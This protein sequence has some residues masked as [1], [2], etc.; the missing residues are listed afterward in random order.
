MKY[1]IFISFSLFL[2]TFCFSVNNASANIVCL[3]PNSDYVVD[4]Q[5]ECDHEFKTIAELNEATKQG[6]VIGPLVAGDQVWFK[7][8]GV[9]REPLIVGSSGEIDKPIIY[10]AYG[11]TGLRRPEISCS[12]D[13]TKHLTKGVL[14]NGNFEDTPAGSSCDT[15]EW[16]DR[17]WY[18]MSNCAAIYNE[19]TDNHVLQVDNTAETQQVKS[20]ELGLQSGTQ[21]QIKGEIRTSGTAS[22]ELRLESLTT[23]EYFGDD[24]IWHA[25]S[26]GYLPFKTIQSITGVSFNELLPGIDS[27]RVQLRMI[28]SGTGSVWFDNIEIVDTQTN[29]WSAKTYKNG[30]HNIRILAEGRNL[31][32]LGGDGVRLSRGDNWSTTDRWHIVGSSNKLL[33][34]IPET[35]TPEKMVEISAGQVGILLR[36]KDFVHINNLIVSGCEAITTNAEFEGAAILLSG[37]SS[38]NTISNVLTINNN[39][40]IRVQGKNIVTN[41]FNTDNLFTDF[42]VSNSISQGIALRSDSVNNTIQNC[43]VHDLNML[44]SDNDRFDKEPI[45]IGGDKGNFPRTVEESGNLIQNCTVYNSGINADRSTGIV[46][47]HSPK[48]MVLRNRI[49]NIGKS[50]IVIGNLSDGSRIANNTIKDVGLSPYPLKATG[51]ASNMGAGIAIVPGTESIS[52]VQAINNSISGC[53]NNN[54]FYGAIALDNR[55]SA[56]TMSDIVIKNNVIHGCTGDYPYVL[57][58]FEAGYDTL[59]ID[60]NHYYRDPSQF[61]KPLIMY[62]KGSGDPGAGDDSYDNYTT[63]HTFED[64]QSDIRTQTQNRDQNSAFSDPLFT[65]TA[66]HDLLLL[67]ESRAIDAGNPADDYSTEPENN[68]DRINM[69]AYGNTQFATVGNDSDNDGITD[70][71]D[72]CPYNINPQQSDIDNDGLGDICDDDIDGDGYS[73]IFDNCPIDIN[74]NQTDTD[75]DNFGNVCDTETLTL[76]SI[77]SDDGFLVESGENTD[78]GG[79]TKSTKTGGQSLRIG[80]TSK[81]KQLKSIVSFNTSEILTGSIVTMARLELSQGSIRNNPSNLGNINVDLSSGGFGGN[82]ILENTDFEATATIPNMTQL[83]DGSAGVSTANINSTGLTLISTSN[84]IQL[85]F[86]YES[87]DNNNDIRDSRGYYSADNDT[88]NNRPRLVIEYNL[89][90]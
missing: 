42:V 81:R 82:V 55:N 14:P 48:T 53:T 71:T 79:S 89:P 8:E 2:I 87:D 27:A 15:N 80:D 56:G 9:W 13:I 86:A 4:T 52:D 75:G 17:G 67:P 41:E 10:T 61:G 11:D 38:N 23:T 65:A 77:N 36:D 73:N 60:Y 21:Y 44:P 34:Y 50:G 57:Y 46:T 6:G 20:T 70:Q 69:G 63:W 31:N 19:L 35:E 78:V 22:V 7:R 74:R 1:K 29:Y 90:D 26:N 64:Y 54:T 72:N 62:R 59:Q 85:R 39:H 33:R 66:E 16:K 68:G 58:V 24:N 40:G 49:Y 18:G 5:Y 76:I 88:V 30:L 45:S 37:G 43:T 28:V 25:V 3:D 83:I 12:A 84:I 47:F 32:V 51:E